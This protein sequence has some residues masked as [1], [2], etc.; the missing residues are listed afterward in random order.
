MKKR[1]SI[2]ASAVL[3]SG[4]GVA[5]AASSDV[6]V[7][8]VTQLPIEQLLTTEFTPASRIARQISDAP[9]AVSIVT[10]QDIRDQGYRSLADILKS[11]RGL[12]V[13]S[14]TTY[15][16]LGG[17]G[18]GTPGDFAGR[19]L[20]M[21]DGYAT[22]DNVY[23]QIFLNEDALLDVAMIDRV[24]YVPGPG[25]TTY[26][27]GAFL[28]VINIVTKHGKDF[29]GTQIAAGFGSQGARKQRLTFGKRLEN[30]AD[31]LANFSMYGDQGR[32]IQFP[33][34]DSY[35][36]AN[37]QT[38]TN[39]PLRVREVNNRRLFFKETYR[40]WT[41]EIGHARQQRRNDGFW[42]FYLAT[43]IGK[44]VREVDD[45]SFASLK[46][47]ADLGEQLKASSHLYYGQ[48]LYTYEGPNN[49]DPAQFYMQ[50]SVG[51]W[52]GLDEKFVGTWFDRH[53]VLF[54]AE[55]REDYQQK[56]YDSAIVSAF[57]IRADGSMRTYSLY[58]QDEYILSDTLTLV[59]GL[60]YDRNSKSG[61]TS[62]PRLAAIYH[63][64]QASTFKL[65]YGKAFR[66]PNAW[67]Y[68]I[69][70]YNRNGWGNLNMASALKAESIE[71][72]ELVWQQQFTSET[73]LTTSLYR[74]HIT[75]TISGS[76]W[77]GDNIVNT[78]GQELGIE[79]V[80][81]DG[82]RLNAS[83]AHQHTRSGGGWEFGNIPQWLGKLNLV[84]PLFRNS[85]NA[86]F[87]VQNTGR[88]RDM[89][90]A[91]STVKANTVAN[92]TFDSS[93]LIDGANV[94]FRIRNLFNTH[95]EDV[96][97]PFIPMVTMPLAGR[98]YW[99]QLEYTIK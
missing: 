1:I 82:F 61:H 20:L 14:S 3:L 77:L 86:G 90:A 31:V 67:E 60:R 40:G 6:D 11:M 32:D 75:D 99:L 22:N 53:Q 89:S 36:D 48:Y 29:S 98:Q 52:W 45:N 73:R 70:D 51:R 92:L 34:L 16:F 78:E 66:R 95:Q 54:G 72:T 50:Q 13:T 83:I 27:N 63:P 37:G 44:T 94:S 42:D 10:A 35:V 25:S 88:R 58:A 38:L 21:I 56:F 7:F 43:D 8:D 93:R 41:A 80:E 55:F 18:Y 12:Y 69:L 68:F 46:Y 9:S 62:S 2:V 47:D 19:V 79:H 17:R 26:G 24:E 65:S 4:F 81:Q 87:E 59:P 30:G 74:N 39:Q 64:W 28:G 91:H 33:A 15:D 49:A 84:Q 96:L 76:M 85:V 97:G 5:Q 57:G 71:T 23:N